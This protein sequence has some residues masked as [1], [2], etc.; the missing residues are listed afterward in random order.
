MLGLLE[1]EEGKQMQRWGG[2]QNGEI[3]DGFVF[4]NQYVDG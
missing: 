4:E 1:V 2:L 3:F